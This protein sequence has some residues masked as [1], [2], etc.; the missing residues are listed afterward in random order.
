[1]KSKRFK[2]LTSSTAMMAIHSFSLPANSHNKS[3][4]KFVVHP[5]GVVATQD[6]KALPEGAVFSYGRDGSHHFVK[7]NG[8]TYNKIIYG[9]T[10]VNEWTS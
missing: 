9:D 6:G 10:V 7:Y 8:V 3:G 2:K 4:F 1:M 5:N